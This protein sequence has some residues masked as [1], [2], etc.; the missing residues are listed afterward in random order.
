MLDGVPGMVEIQHIDRLS[1]VGCVQSNIVRSVMT[2]K[3]V[4]VNNKATQSRQLVNHFGKAKP[5]TTKVN[6]S[7]LYNNAIV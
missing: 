6:C 7:I 1:H 5:F 3:A 4:D 2:V